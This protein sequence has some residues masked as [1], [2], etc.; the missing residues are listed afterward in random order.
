MKMSYTTEPRRITS[1]G[2]FIHLADRFSPEAVELAFRR[3]YTGL[4]FFDKHIIRPGYDTGQVRL[5]LDI[6][7]ALRPNE[8][9]SADEQKLLRNL[10]P[11]ASKKP[12]TKQIKPN[13]PNLC[14]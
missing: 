14:K 5:A 8:T 12:A 6:V 7:K 9:L 13:N 4:R 1:P 11:R 2:F 3:M 10:D